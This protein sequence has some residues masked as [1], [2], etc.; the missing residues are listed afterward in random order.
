MKLRK[1]IE[2]CETFFPSHYSCCVSSDI[3]VKW[4]FV[5]ATGN[6]KVHNKLGTNRWQVFASPHL[7][8]LTLKPEVLNIFEA[9]FF[10]IINL[11]G[12]KTIN[13]MLYNSFMYWLSK[14][15][16][17]YSNL[18]YAKDFIISLISL[19]HISLNNNLMT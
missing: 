5:R 4:Q 18:H 3:N 16:M 10:N 13:K 8:G 7:I 14:T 19:I 12:G 2:R 11:K 6:R 9:D 17:W 15:L 1:L